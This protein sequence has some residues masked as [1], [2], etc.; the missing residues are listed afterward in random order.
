MAGSEFTLTCRITKAISELTNMPTAIWN[1]DGELVTSGGDI[2]VA[3]SSN[4]TVAIA[5]VT[6]DPLRA[7]HGKVYRCVGVLMS[8]AQEESIQETS[9]ER[10]TVHCKQDCIV[11]CGLVTCVCSSH[12]C[13]VHLC[14]S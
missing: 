7:S 5:T 2:T 12:S 14:V 13:C 9:E 1:V 8:P 4:D 10:L 3:T 6:F 11:T